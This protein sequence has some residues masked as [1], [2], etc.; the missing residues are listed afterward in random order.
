MKAG[1]LTTTILL[2]SAFEALGQFAFEN[3]GFEHWT[4]GL[5][6]HWSEVM[7]TIGRYQDNVTVELEQGFKCEG[8]YSAR[9]HSI[10]PFGGINQPVLQGMPVTWNLMPDSAKA[11]VH[12]AKA[13]GTSAFLTNHKPVQ[14][15]FILPVRSELSSS[16]RNI[17][18]LKIDNGD[19]IELFS[20]SSSCEQTWEGAVYLKRNQGEPQLFIDFPGH[21]TWAIPGVMDMGNK[22][23][24]VT[25][26]L[27]CDGQQHLYATDVSRVFY[28]HLK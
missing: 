3:A 6:D 13:N 27:G 2:A 7:D 8:Y 20:A 15:D 18:S 24:F 9:V 25:T 28:Y 26:R 14:E 17:R 19:Y 11:A 23:V 16:I 22:Y 10:Q 1:S 4:D 5:P 12:Y 21:R